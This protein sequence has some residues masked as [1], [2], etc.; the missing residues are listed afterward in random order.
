MG[1]EGTSC[2]AKG[3]GAY[4]ISIKPWASTSPLRQVAAGELVQLP[5]A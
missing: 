2:Q 5:Q 3:A 4:Q 1:I